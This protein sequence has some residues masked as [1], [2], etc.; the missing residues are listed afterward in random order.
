MNISVYITLVTLWSHINEEKNQEDLKNG[1]NRSIRND[2]PK[3]SFNNSFPPPVNGVFGFST[4]MCTTIMLRMMRD[5]ISK[6][7]NLLIKIHP[8]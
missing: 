8:F 6:N 2:K 1:I 3:Q 4:D 5:F 7:S